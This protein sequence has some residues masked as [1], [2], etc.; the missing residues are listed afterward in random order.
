MELT[1]PEYDRHDFK[2]HD[3]VCLFYSSKDQQL[4][5]VFDFIQAGLEQ[6]KKCLYIFHE[7]R[8]HFILEKLKSEGVD[9][10]SALKNGDLMI[11]DKREMCLHQSFFDPDYMIKK[12]KH[13]SDLAGSEGYEG[14]RITGEMSWAC[15]NYPGSDKLMEYEAKLNIFIPGRNITS[16]CQYK[17][18]GF[19]SR[20][21]IQ[22]IQTHPKI[23]YKNV[24]CENGYY[25]PPSE[26]LQKSDIDHSVKRMLNQILR[27]KKFEAEVS[28]GTSL[29]ILKNRMLKRRVSE[30]E[31]ALRV[32]K[33]SESYFRKLVNSAPVGIIVTDTGG[34]CLFVNEY[35]QVLSGLTQQESIGTGWQKAIHPGDVGKIG[36]WW[37][38]GE[39]KCTDPGTECRIC[40]TDGETKWI[41]LKSAPLHDDNGELIGFIASF[42]EITHRKENEYN[43]MDRIIDLGHRVAIQGL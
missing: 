37:Y 21:I 29:M 7:N 15:E 31:K 26:F 10:D 30:R 36:S 32:F 3:H 12:T 19:S 18:N 6:R 4:S 14:L 41:D 23:I 42:S 1:D 9:V 40:T 8:P 33:E 16:L 11:L 39:K 13:Y 38:R 25:I 20:M 27:R 35:W 34:R 5:A 17:M 43:L 28:N 2:C 22:A 24:L